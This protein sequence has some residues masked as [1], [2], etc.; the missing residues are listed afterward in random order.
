MDGVIYLL[1][2]A[3]EGEKAGQL[4]A[5]W[6]PVQLRWFIRMDQDPLPFLEWMPIEDL[7]QD[8][9]PELCVA[10]PIFVVETKATCHGCGSE[11]KVITLAAERLADADDLSQAELIDRAAAAGGAY[12]SD[13]DEDGEDDE[14]YFD[15]DGDDDNENGAGAENEGG[16]LM[17]FHFIRELPADVA[18]FLA[19]FYPY[20]LKRKNPGEG[21]EAYFCNRCPC[22]EAFE[23]FALHAEPGKGFYL[24]SRQ[25]A[26]K[27]ALRELPTAETM[28]IRANFAIVVPD[29]IRKFAQQRPFPAD[30]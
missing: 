26:Q 22:G 10:A 25:D 11:S 8:E 29:V 7:E 20:F 23:D 2:P 3:E 19:R 28:L 14:I 21:D 17:R 6:D 30:S 13:L 27:V 4:G 16:G 12:R 15:D 5:Q 24:F 1:V 9:V 18:C